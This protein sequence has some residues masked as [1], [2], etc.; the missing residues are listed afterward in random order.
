VALS[1]IWFWLSPAR[2]RFMRRLAAPGLRKLKGRLRQSGSRLA[3]AVLTTL[4]DA[5]AE[6]MAHALSKSGAL[7]AYAALATERSVE[8]CFGSLLIYSVNLF[9]RDDFAKNDSELIALLAAILGLSREQVMLRRDALRKTPRS[10]EWML[11]TW[12]LK[13]LGAPAPAFDARVEARFGYQYVG[14]MSQYRDVIEERLRPE[15]PP[16]HV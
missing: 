13:D 3:V 5:N 10:E 8:A 6:F 14:Y 2:R 9:A 16:A 1:G 7:G 4:L 15:G 12:L 11:Y